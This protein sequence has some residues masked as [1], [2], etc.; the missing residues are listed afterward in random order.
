MRDRY[1]IAVCLVLVT[2]GMVTVAF[3][4][5]A[6]SILIVL[7]L[8]AAALF[9]FRRFSSEREFLTTIFLGAL[10]VRLAFGVFIHIMDYRDFFGGDAYTY[11]FNGWRLVEYWT[12]QVRSD[13][14]A[15]QQAWATSGPGWGMNY[16]VAGIYYAIGRNIFAAQS[17]CAVF[18]AATAPMVYFC[19]AKMFS[20]KS[21]AKI[22]AVAIAFFPSFV[23]WSS[24][25]MKDGLIIFLLVLAMTMVLQ[26]QEKFNYLALL[27]LIF[28]LFGI[29]SLRFYIFYMVAIAVA[30]SFIVGL[31]GSVQSLVRRVAVLVLLGLGLTYLG[32]IRNAG[33]DLERFGSL[34][35]V[36][37]SRQDLATSAESGFGGDIDVSTTEG[38]IS[39]VPIG[40][41]YLMF[42][43]FPWEVTNLR[44]AITLPEVLLWWAMIPLLVSGLWY[45]IRHRLGKSI[46]VLVFSLMLTLAYSIFQG[47]VG[48]AYR[49][50]T[51]IQV[52][53]FIFIA[54]GF[55]IFREARENKRLL[56]A[57]RRK[58]VDDSLRARSSV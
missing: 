45:A 21:V 46:P 17:F 32:V 27:L 48:T 57:A 23:I 39:A 56:V 22:S 30:G 20:N 44:Q 43:P 25:L 29:L 28:S 58:Q 40:L 54:V 14:L 50:R 55:T 16:L 3:P 52:F 15:L 47:N 51:Q 36:Q 11:D 4:E 13:D 5:G 38:A 31:T 10:L 49:Q 34:E 9:I 2:L 18:G 41:L 35:Q 7:V 6:A 8:S 12:G 24:Q 37:N 33:V 53:L 42:A 19:A 26:L 1:L